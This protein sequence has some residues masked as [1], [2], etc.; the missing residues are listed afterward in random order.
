MTS[1]LNKTHDIFSSLGVEP[2]KFLDV[3][4]TK[5]FPNRQVGVLKTYSPQNPFINHTHR[6]NFLSRTLAKI[7]IKKLSKGMI[8]GVLFEVKFAKIFK[9]L[10]KNA[11]L[12]IW[13]SITHL[14]CLVPH[15]IQILQ[16]YNLDF[17]RE[18]KKEEI[19]FGTFCLM[20][21]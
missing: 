3:S 5:Y 17:F 19:L 21:N 9:G 1:K 16:N 2:T 20:T 14:V 4:I 11:Y 12:K 7:S 13:R 10:P 18:T 6:V 8:N 15:M